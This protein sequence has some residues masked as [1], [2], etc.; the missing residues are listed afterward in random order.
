M[1]KINT[2]Y[3]KF[4]AYSIKDLIVRK[5]SEDTK[6]TDQVYEGS[7]LNILIDMV[8]YMYQCLMFNLNNAA[9]ESMFSDTQIYE[10]INRLCKFIGY[11]PKGMITSNAIFNFNNFDSASGKTKFEGS[12]IFPY[13]A[14]NTGKTDTQGNEIYYSTIDPV[15]V[16]ANH[17]GNLLMYNGKWKQYDTVFTS[18]GDKY[19]TFTLTNLYSD[20]VSKKYVV[21]Q[22]IHVYVKHYN[23]DESDYTMIKYKPVT[24][25]LFTDNNVKN[26][27]EIYN[28]A[29]KIYNIRLNENK[30]YE[31]KFGNGING[32]IPAKNDLIYVFYLDSNGPDASLAPGDVTEAVIQHSPSFFGLTLEM[33][34]KIFA[35]YIG[36]D[37]NI[38]NS[39]DP[40]KL[41]NKGVSTSPVYE[42]TVDEIRTNA[43]EWFKVGNRLVTESDYEYYVKNRF[44]DN[45]VDVKCQN[46]WAYIASF[47]KWLYDLGNNGMRV[48]SSAERNGSY[49]INENRI[50]KYDYKYADAADCNNV[51]LWIKMKNDADI[52]TD[53][54][55]EEIKNVKTLTAE[56]VY[57]KPIDVYFSLCAC[58]KKYAYDKYFSGS[59]TKVFDSDAESYLEVTLNDNTVYTTTS[60]KTQVANVITDFFNEN[61]FEI[62]D[63]INFN[64]LLDKILEINGIER[65]RTVWINPDDSTDYLIANGLSFATWSSSYIDVGDDLDISTSTK[66]L[67]PFQFPKLYIQSSLVNK[68]KVI[69]KTIGS[70]NTVQY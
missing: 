61:N 28:D 29:D 40:L 12:I 38:Y 51:Y 46:N 63:S 10:N 54:I 57:L 17:V 34:N 18:S 65:V 69:R 3:L 19:Q 60:I 44:K 33:Y 56:T 24:E 5:L 22:Q 70:T 48:T 20:Y 45:V 66:I 15:I 27:A 2:D 23:A 13:S 26:G 16:N 49:Y 68:I 62:G 52:Y 58:S 6:F 64:D 30:Q 4:N 39:S 8:S 11:N 59:T 36:Y 55:D 7:N 67:E 50:I 1:A 14:I 53:I 35:D 43:P 21:W 41:T 42:E 25:G 47:Y 37:G 9:A 32:M 31:I